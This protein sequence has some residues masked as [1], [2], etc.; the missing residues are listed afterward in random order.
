MVV[1]THWEK[2]HY[3]YCF[4]PTARCIAFYEVLFGT[5][6]SHTSHTLDRNIHTPEYFYIHMHDLKALTNHFSNVCKW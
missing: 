5:Q 2:S 3:F 6:Y 4:T 1:I